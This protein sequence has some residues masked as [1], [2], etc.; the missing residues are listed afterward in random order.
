MMSG[1]GGFAVNLAELWT[2]MDEGVDAVFM[3]MNDH[4][5][6][7]IKHIQ[8]SLYGGRHYFAD[9]SAPDYRGR[10]ALCGMPFFHSDTVAGVGPALEAAL[11]VDGPAMVEVD[12]SAIG[13]YPTYYKPP[14]YADK[15]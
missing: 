10:A 12:M 1:D 15:D 3:I 7:V 2:A 6:G 14:P 5:Y 13:A 9:P 8:T 4:G 11:A